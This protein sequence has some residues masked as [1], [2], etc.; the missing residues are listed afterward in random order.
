MDKK[1]EPV[2][3]SI[4]H[5]FGPLAELARH[6]PCFLYQLK[7]SPDQKFHYVYASENTEALFGIPAQAIMQD[8]SL[9]LGRIHPADA[10]RVYQTSAE[11]AAQLKP[12]HAELRIIRPDEQIIWLEAFDF[13]KQLADGSIL[14]SGFANDISQR[15]AAELKLRRSEAEFRALVE[16]A[17]DIIFTL[18]PN[19]VLDY[20][21]PCWQ[22]ILGH[23]PTEVMGKTF[24]HFVHQ[25]DLERCFAFMQSL[26]LTAT[27]HGTI[28]YRIFHKNGQMRWHTSTAA[29]ILD[30]DGSLIKYV[31]IARDITEQ[32]LQNLELAR[33]AYYDPLTG[34][35]NRTLFHKM[36]EQQLA[37]CQLRGDTLALLFID[38]DRFKPVNDC[39]G[40]AI[41]DEVLQQV[42]Q[43]LHHSTRAADL[44]GRLSGDEFVVA[45][46][47]FT[48]SQP[49]APQILPLASRIQQQLSQPYQVAEHQLT[50][51]CSVGIALF[52][53][54]SLDQQQLLHLADIAMYQAKKRPGQAAVVFYQTEVAERP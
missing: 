15:K 31:G 39:Y 42:A 3:N 45:L 35:A 11:C 19:G 40:H 54:D 9:L 10:E 34:L 28:E 1:S 30:A 32:K 17:S 50:I 27:H 4:E 44:T 20:V 25:D 24:D 43:R 52:P 53:Q 8:A 47:G 41:G 12:W 49:L 46:T 2:S 14:F 21:S 33:Q 38:L 22:D 37:L 7:Q 13:P 16:S 36:L 29:P 51:S 23:H 5:L 18:L 6:L 26:L 48:A